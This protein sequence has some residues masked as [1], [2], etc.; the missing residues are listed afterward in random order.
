MEKIDEDEMEDTQNTGGRVT[1][2]ADA[3]LVDKTEE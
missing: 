2:R 3:K 1:D